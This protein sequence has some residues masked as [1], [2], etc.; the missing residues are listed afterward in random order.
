VTNGKDSATAAPPKANPNPSG[1]P[2]PVVAVGAS[3]GGLEPLQQLFAGVSDESG[4]AFVV[5]QHLDPDRP[6]M[7]TKVLQ[8]GTRLSVVEATSGMALE[9]DRVHVIPSSA[10]LTV[11][12]GNLTLVPRQRTG[13]L[14]LPID[15]FFRSLAAD[16]GGRA[17][18]VVLSG[19]GADGTEGLRAIKAEGG[20]AIA[21]EPDSAQFSSMPEAAIAAGVV[22]FRGS[23]EAITS[24]LMRLSRHPYAAIERAEGHPKEIGAGQE[25]T[26]ALILAALRRH[27]GVD[28]SGYKRSTV[29]RRIQRRTA[30]RHV[31]DIGE[32]AKILEDDAEEGLALARDMLIHVTAFFRDPNAFAALKERV[33]EKLAARKEPG[34]SIRIWVPGCATGEEAYALVMSLLE[35]LDAK[36]TNFSIKVFGTDLSEEAIEVA[37]A[38]VYPEAAVAD[39]SP[40]RLAR[41]FE[42][43]DAGYRIA[44]AVRDACAF[45][46]H[47]LTRDPPFAKLDLI[48]CRNVL[49]YFDA[50][51]QRRVVPMLHY[52]LNPDGFL[53]LGQSET[54]LGFRDMFE[55]VDKEHRIFVKT[56]ESAHLLFPLRAG[57]DP[58]AK[59]AGRRPAAPQP[60]ADARRQAD[61]LMLTRYAPPGVLVNSRLEIIQFRG[62]TGT[63][64]EPPP[65]QPQAN[66]LRMARGGLAAHLREAIERAKTEGT[67]VRKDGLRFELGSELQVVDMEVVPLASVGDSPERYFLVL[68]ETVAAKRPPLERKPT[69]RESAATPPRADD[70]HTREAERVKAEL[71]ATKDYVQSLM[72]EHQSTTDELAAANEELI[73]ANEELQS[74]NEELS[75]AREELQSTNEELNTVNEELHGR[76]E[77]LVRVNSD[78]TNLLA[79]IQT[80]VVIVG[81]DLRIRRFTPMAERTL[82]L[83]PSDIARP[84]QHIKP[85]IDCE[86]LEDRI[87]AVIDGV[88][89]HHGEVR[90][91]QGRWLA[92]GIRPYK[93]LEN[94]ID[95]AV[96]T[97]VDIDEQKRL[98]TAMRDEQE[99]SQA[100]EDAVSEWVVVLDASL[101]VRKANAA[102]RGAFRLDGDAALDRPLVE[103]GDGWGDSRVQGLFE[104]A[105][106]RAPRVDGV[107]LDLEFSGLGPRRLALQARRIDKA[108]ESPLLLLVARDHTPHSREEA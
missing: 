22:D 103:I 28:F 15:S 71:T 61:H 106:S 55:N 20:I 33:F 26:L 34:D 2:F 45:V 72:S 100:V 99:L 36:K 62:R 14:H 11:K 98:E 104:R 108:S 84:I 66:V 70:E 24:E 23:P 44:S 68:F 57:R 102:F 12:D 92:L 94:R 53:F 27:A 81:G 18:G 9:P 51:L 29:L 56:G 21:Q 37:R 59:L 16:S 43:T 49:I 87:R 83:I 48:S 85:N 52:C 90:D 60:N 4:M 17:I 63:Y 19:S 95:G 86:D 75:T 40:E 25:K 46:K 1:A 10:D 31:D 65:G 8:G 32:Y 101:R 88:T 41:F 91:A 13:R 76:N 74:T 105:L 3:A 42:R 79:S 5:I 50:E 96:L 30:L 77:E 82:N 7:L 54:I 97:L 6:S 69:D 78:L 64:L 47:D 93:D 80:A 38:A 107:E 89:P 39:V 58:E 35:S 73:A 67:T